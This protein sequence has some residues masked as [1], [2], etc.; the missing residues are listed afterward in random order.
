MMWVE[1]EE[2]V[3]CDSQIQMDKQKYF[4]GAQF[5]EVQFVK[6]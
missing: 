1:E 2:E 4:L 3:A 5:D 6:V